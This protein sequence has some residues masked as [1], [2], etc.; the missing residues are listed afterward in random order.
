MGQLETA[1]APG[2]LGV[3]DRANA[4]TVRLFGGALS[5][6][7]D[8]DV[9]AG[10][11]GAAIRTADGGWEVL[12]F[13]YAELTGTR[14]YRISKLLRGQCGTEDA[15]R[16]GAAPGAD[17][18]LLDRAVTTLPV[19]ADLLKV[20]IRYRFGPGR[21]DYAAP[22][23]AEHTI[24]AEGVALK[25]FAPVH[26]RARRETGSG[27]ILL[28]W[29]RRTRFGG[30]SWDMPDVPLNEESEAYRVEIF[31]GDQLRRGVETSAPSF[32]YSAGEQGADF[33]GPAPEFTVRIAQL[34]LAAGPGFA[35]QEIVHV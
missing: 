18:V 26:L 22:S 14:Q 4:A 17:F 3:F 25:P 32:R 27:D 29:T 2:P 9:L 30:D 33:A 15:M 8:I 16:A 28:R 5:S 12:Q 10:G 19:R 24:V 11:N 20:P 21:D 7:P 31:E 1:L 6:L 23:F 34:S 13:A 35:L